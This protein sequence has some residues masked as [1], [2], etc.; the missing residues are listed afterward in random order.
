MQTALLAL[1]VTVTLVALLRSSLRRRGS[2]KRPRSADLPPRELLAK[3]RKDPR[4]WGVTLRAPADGTACKA[5]L[6]HNGRNIG[7]ERAPQLPLVECDSKQC[8]CRYIGL[9]NRR[10]GRSH[11][12]GT[13]RRH[14]DLIQWGNY[15]F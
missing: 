15:G 4:Y 2:R 1:L 9:K 13:E 14:N 7:V 6:K 12:G 11:W 10:Q 8:C 3:L 5:A